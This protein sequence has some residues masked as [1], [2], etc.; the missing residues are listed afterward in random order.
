[1]TNEEKAREIAG[2][3]TGCL[4]ERK[5]LNCQFDCANKGK[6]YGALKMAEWKDQ[7]FKERL[8]EKRKHLYNRYNFIG[9]NAVVCRVLLD[10]IINEL[11]EETESDNSDREE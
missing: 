8:E 9:N 3:C 7:Q 6:Y 4:D 10:E 1:M 5:N 2:L 11:F